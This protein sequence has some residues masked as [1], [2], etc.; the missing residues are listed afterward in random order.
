MTTVRLRAQPASYGHV[1][2]D[3]LGSGGV[4]ADARDPDEA[5]VLLRT[6]IPRTTLDSTGTTVVELEPT[7][8]ISPAGTTYRATFWGAGRTPAT[9][10]FT[11]PV[12]GSVVDAT[13]YE[14]DP[15][16]TLPPTALAAETSARIAADGVL[17]A[18]IDGIAVGGAPDATTTSKGIVRLAGD[19]GGTA[20]SPTVPGLAGKETPA[21]AQ[22]KADA[23][24][25]A[26]IA[27]SQPLDSDLSA[28]A[29]LT[30]VAFGRGLLT[31]ADAAALRTLAALGT[32]ATANKVAAGTAGV[33]DATDA[34]TTNAR[35]PTGH[36]ASHASAG[37]DPVGLAASQVTSGVFNIA[38]L[39]TGT[40]DGT[41]FVRD[42][43]TLAAPPGGGDVVVI[44]S[45]VVGAGGAASIDFTSIPSTYRN[46]R[47]LF[48]G[49][50]SAGASLNGHLIRFNN[51]SANNYDY[52]QLRVTNA[53]TVGG[54]TYTGV[55]TT[56]MG[57]GALANATTQL[58]ILVFDYANTTALK[59]GWAREN[60]LYTT[61]LDWNQIMHYRWHDTSAINRLS[62]VPDAA[63]APGSVA[64][65]YGMKG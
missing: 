34:S 52:N 36:A 48:N 64:T 14:T 23:A 1:R 13:A 28:I 3:L 59:G 20:L 9:L 60:S 18:E 56:V 5:A 40:P 65:L 24:Q 8:E 30:T 25:A 38:R 62:L 26:A 19:L 46:L 6:P 55:Y 51:D 2:V 53:V 58:E 39:A 41:K 22:A 27:A 50:L 15:P 29:A 49:R 42:D 35:T 33:L 45:V 17:Q 47:V 31:A 12:S 4:P 21:G 11:V 63:Y 54:S 10:V 16:G 32:A 57:S 7:S 37:S 43:G 61:T 44:A